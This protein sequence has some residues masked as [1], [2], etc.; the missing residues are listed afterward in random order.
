MILLTNARVHSKVNND[1]Y[2]Y[3]GALKNKVT[4]SQM[5]KSI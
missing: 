3:V 2:L 4:S 1:I 5:M